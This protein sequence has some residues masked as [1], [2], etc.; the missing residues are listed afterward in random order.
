MEPS[1]YNPLSRITRSMSRLRE[2]VTTA[3]PTTPDRQDAVETVVP[4]SAIAGRV[5][6]TPAVDST[7]I[8]SISEASLTVLTIINGTP[9][10]CQPH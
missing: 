6:S 8:H 10:P 9:H 7:A 1:P 3:L 4:G 5:P 2:A